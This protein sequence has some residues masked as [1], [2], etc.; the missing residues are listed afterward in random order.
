M[1]LICIFNYKKPKSEM[2]IRKSTEPG[3]KNLYPMIT[4]RV[5][6][7]TLIIKKANYI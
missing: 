6:V 3:V 2:V 7:R 1:V 4:D 5:N